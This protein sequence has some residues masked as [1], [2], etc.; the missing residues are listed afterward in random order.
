MQEEMKRIF[1]TGIGTGIGK[2]LV[3]ACVTEALQAAYW[4]PVQ[5]GLEDGTDTA[6]VAALVSRPENCL[7]EA[8]RLKMPASPHLA[9]REEGITIHLEQ[10]QAHLQKSLP[11][12]KALVIEGAG[13]LMVPL[14]E[15]EFTTDLIRALNATVIIVSQHYLGS[16]NHSMLTALALQQANIPVAGW[17]FNGDEHTNETDI[18]R[19]SNIPRIGRIPQTT[20]PGKDFVTRQAALL[21]PS[22]LKLFGA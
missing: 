20:Q 14:N 11:Q 22:L 4:K 16:I 15:T 3:A 5:A 9:A 13:G 8:Y 1:I 10:I 6:T 17:I 18:V 7:T 19:W 21:Q 2:T 12:N